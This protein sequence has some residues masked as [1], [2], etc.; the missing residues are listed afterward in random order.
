V[1]LLHEPAW[2]GQVFLEADEDGVK[3]VAQVLA[4]GQHIRMCFP[5]SIDD[6]PVEIRPRKSA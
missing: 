4:D 6:I 5:R 2:L 1:G 3:I